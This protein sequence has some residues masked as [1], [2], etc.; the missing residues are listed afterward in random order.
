[1]DRKD[2]YKFLGKDLKEGEIT[3][4]DITEDFGVWKKEDWELPK[5]YVKQTLKEVEKM[6]AEIYKHIPNFE[7]GESIKSHM[8]GAWKELSIVV[9]ELKYLL[10]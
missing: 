9:T 8:V 4:K 7:S 3:A 2:W 10:K 5:K 1:M 6:K